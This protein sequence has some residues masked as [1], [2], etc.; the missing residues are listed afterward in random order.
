MEKTILKGSWSETQYTAE[1]L[2]YISNFLQGQESSASEDEEDD[3]NEQFREILLNLS[4]QVYGELKE[5]L[6][7]TLDKNF[8]DSDNSF[9]ELRDLL[10]LQGYQYFEAAIPEVR[11]TSSPR[12]LKIYIEV[13]R[14]FYEMVLEN[15]AVLEEVWQN[16]PKGDGRKEKVL[17]FMRQNPLETWGKRARQY[18]REELAR[19]S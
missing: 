11:L 4:K 16:I 5:E 13:K 2:N 3:R 10:T 17:G 9:N 7:V 12:L 15:L 19:A 14:K 1:L 6:V 8:E 18:F